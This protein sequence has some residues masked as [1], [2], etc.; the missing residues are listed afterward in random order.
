MSK[1]ARPLMKV[2][3]PLAKKVLAPLGIMEAASAIDAGFQ[4]MIQNIR[5]YIIYR[6]SKYM[7]QQP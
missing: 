7:E 2:A 3:I 1:L 6:N 4:K 5:E